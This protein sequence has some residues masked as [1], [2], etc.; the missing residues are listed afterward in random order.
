[1]FH[2]AKIILTVVKD[3][4]SQL[5]ATK[6]YLGTQGVRNGMFNLS[7]IGGISIWDHTIME[8]MQQEHIT[9]ERL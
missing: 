2:E 7:K 1:M 3:R 6:G 4:A 5:Q 9:T 8:L